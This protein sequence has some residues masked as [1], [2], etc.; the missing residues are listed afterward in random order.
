MYA[1]PS[2]GPLALQRDESKL[3]L[4]VGSVSRPDLALYTSAGAPLGRVLWGGGRVVAAGWAA[5]ERLLVVEERGQVGG[6]S[7]RGGGGGGA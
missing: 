7:E 4:F 1:A 3:V 2:G 6:W 5:D